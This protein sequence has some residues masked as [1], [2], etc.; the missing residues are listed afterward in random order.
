MLPNLVKCI[1]NVFIF[2]I[3]LWIMESKVKFNV[4]Y[5]DCTLYVMRIYQVEP[6]KVWQHLTEKD[7]LD[8]WWAPKPW[9]CTTEEF[10]FREGGKWKYAMEGPQGEKVYTGTEFTEITEGRSILWKDFFLNENGK[11]DTTLPSTSWLIGFTGVEEGTKLTF[12]LHLPSKENLE[13]LLEMGFEEG[14]T[15]GLNQL[16]DVLAEEN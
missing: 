15:I 11:I 6:R 4:N 1:I 9:K 8:K 2:L 3:K 7:L 10:D 12:N 16:T 5:D 14:F 13:Q